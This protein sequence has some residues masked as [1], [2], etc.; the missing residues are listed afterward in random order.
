MLPLPHSG[1]DIQLTELRIY[2]DTR[3]ALNCQ[4]WCSALD[5]HYFTEPR[6]V[7]ERDPLII[8][9]LHKPVTTQGP[10]QAGGQAGSAL[11]LTPTLGAAPGTWCLSLQMHRAPPQEPGAL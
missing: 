4:T 10:G 6:Q 3:Q 2:Y 5:P 1:S 8:T 7:H 9:S 11:P